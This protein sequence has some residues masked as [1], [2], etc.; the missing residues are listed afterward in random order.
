MASAEEGSSGQITPIAAHIW[1]EMQPSPMPR[2]KA[3]NMAIGMEGGFIHDVSSVGFKEAAFGVLRYIKRQDAPWAT[4]EVV[5]INVRSEY[6]K[7]A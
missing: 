4:Q 2:R 3:T 1:G 5:T 7:K 6:T